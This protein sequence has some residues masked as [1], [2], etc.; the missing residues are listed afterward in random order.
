MIMELKQLEYLIAAVEH[1]SLSRAAEHLYTSQP[2]VSKILSGLEKEL[3]VQILERS[4][5]GVTLTNVGEQ[6]YLYAKN[7][8]RTSELIATVADDKS[9]DQL[10]I[11]S[12]SSNMIANKLTEYYKT[13]ENKV[14]VAYLSGT[15]EEVIEYV[16]VRKVDIGIV[17]YPDHMKSAFKQILQHKDLKF[18]LFK[19][20][21]MC[22]YVGPEHP[23]Y[24]RDWVRFE[25]L[26]EL[27]F[28][29]WI[30]EYFSLEEYIEVLSKKKLSPRDLKHMIHTNS[31]HV[32]KNILE[33]TNV[34]NL[35][36]DL[37]NEA[38]RY[39]A[40][41]TIG[42]EGCENFLHV[43]YIIRNSYTLKSHEL[44]FLTCVNRL[45]K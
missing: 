27:E 11:A 10:K 1:K 41:K 37:I 31:E 13:S 9:Y 23:Y 15:I 26:K 28:I 35:G 42:L 24:E 12:Y 38:D 5:K 45:F 29:Q 20:C 40:I 8:V 30:K 2:N 43:G 18:N 34:C 25:D 6:I 3:K 39:P 19:K 21:K 17:F 14:H 32:M 4:S 33:K 22:L 16:A 36:L 44:E 7:M